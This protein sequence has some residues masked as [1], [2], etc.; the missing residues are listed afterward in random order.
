MEDNVVTIQPIDPDELDK[1]VGKDVE[2][3]DVV[4]DLTELDKDVESVVLPLEA[5]QQILDAAKESGN[6]TEALVIKLPEVIVELDDKTMHVITDTVEG[7]VALSVNL[8]EVEDLNTDQKQALKDKKTFGGIDISLVCTATGEKVTDFEGGKVTMKV[9][10]EVPANHKANGFSVWHVAED[11]KLTKMT[12]KYEDGHLV[13]GTGHFSD[14]IIIYEE[15]A[16]EGNQP[17]GS[18]SG[19]TGNDGPSKTG[20]TAMPAAFILLAT[21]SITALT[22]ISLGKK[23][24]F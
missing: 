16:P 19:S 18:G 17:G 15:P 20:D 21:M 7:D 1:V 14:Y 11:G 5:V 23:K 10:F 9:P 24:F 6:D 13:F 4:V 12:T 8:I 3:G 22:V 2:T